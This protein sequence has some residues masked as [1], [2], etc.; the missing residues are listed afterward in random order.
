[1]QYVVQKE[2]IVLYMKFLKHRLLA[3][4]LI[5][6]FCVGLL[7]GCSLPGG[8]SN[9]TASELAKRSKDVMSNVESY[10]MDLNMEY[11]VRVN[12]QGEGDAV[13]T[14]MGAGVDNF[15]TK[16]V[17]DDSGQPV[18]GYIHGNMSA[19]MYGMEVDVPLEMYLDKK[20]GNGSIYTSTDGSSWGVESLTDDNNIF[21][22]VA[23]LTEIE[24]V[25]W[26]MDKD[27]VKVGNSEVYCLSATVNSSLI[28]NLLTLNTDALVGA[29][30][31]V[32]PDVKLTEYVDKDTFYVVGIHITMA[33]DAE[34]L[35]VDTGTSEYKFNCLNI[36]TS[37]NNFNVFDEDDVLVTDE[38]KS[39]AKSK[40]N[41][42][43]ILTDK[44][45]SDG[46]MIIRNSNWDEEL[47]SSDLDAD[48]V[49]SSD[50][51]KVGFEPTNE[52]KK[53]HVTENNLHVSGDGSNYF[54]NAHVGKWFDGKDSVTEEQHVTNTYYNDLKAEGV[55]KDITIG[56]VQ[57]T[58]LGQYPVYWYSAQYTHVDGSDKLSFV[59]K[60]YSFSVDLGDGQS[61]D[62]SVSEYSDVGSQVNLSNEAALKF[63][64][65]FVIEKE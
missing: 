34:D 62:I 33:D 42:K 25:D 17:R 55:M 19:N 6:S 2:R 31:I 15:T 13:S 49:L 60:E 53:F 11:D 43:G 1:M 63:L 46:A 18:L 3:L 47:S 27:T 39:V 16:I 65:Q 41:S 38:I 64:S 37:Y 8:S 21:G 51:Y 35:S 40:L 20:E 48:G 36:R 57:S 28:E 52:L 54:I 10:S 7:S 22:F 50:G 23:E 61:C 56:D 5:S 44:L 24:D 58:S 45:E 32:F 9:M 14:N 29:D 12:T 26:T 59:Y 4:V 30:D